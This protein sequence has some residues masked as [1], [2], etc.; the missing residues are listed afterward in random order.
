MLKFS[1]LVD[2]SSCFG[3]QTG[4]SL[5]HTRCHAATQLQRSHTQAQRPA[6]SKQGTCTVRVMATTR[7]DTQRHTTSYV[8]MQQLYFACAREYTDTETGKPPGI[9]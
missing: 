8:H 5:V 9:A 1:G 4:K 3:K 7:S 6:Y 2:L